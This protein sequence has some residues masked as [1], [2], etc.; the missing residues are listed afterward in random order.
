MV[1]R[2]VPYLNFQ[3]NCEDA[4]I[5]YKKILDG[6]IEIV[7][8]YDN[9]AMQIPTDYKNKIL[10]ARFTIADMLFFASDFFPGRTLERGN[11]DIALSLDADSEEEGQRIFLLLSKDGEVVVPFAKQFWGAWHGNIIDKYGIKWMINVNK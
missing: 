5:Y 1:K 8:R 4:L 9:P 3:G 7:N 6:E 10:H 11:G 2:L